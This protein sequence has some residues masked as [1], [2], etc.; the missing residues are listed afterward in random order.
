MI[1]LHTHTLLSDGGLIPAEHI[2]R[3]QVAGYK[4]LGLADHADLA[5][6]ERIIPE[7]LTAARREN[8][9]GLMRVVAGI[10]L[11]HLRPAHIAEATELAR[12]LG[13]QFVICHGETIAEPVLAGT[14]DAA[15]AAGVDILAHP[16]LVT[17]QQARRAAAKGV[18]L[19]I[20]GKG[21]HC[22]CN[23]HVAAVGRAAG[24]QLMFG[25]DAHD[26][27]QMPDRAYAEAICRG[28]GLT[29]AEVKRM[30]DAARKF[31]M[32]M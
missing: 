6:M 30:F 18:R 26:C 10:E 9:L 5:T 31:A 32:A 23:G 7:L 29:A 20:S 25:S 22:L 1:D 3:A 27:N 12:K 19:E 2:R 28:A 4:I 11:T 21:G 16:G 14:N 8:E 15:I 13:A 24:A 17:P